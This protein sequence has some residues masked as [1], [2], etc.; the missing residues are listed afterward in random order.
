LTGS[1]DAIL[2]MAAWFLA[3]NAPGL[4]IERRGE[5]VG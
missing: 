3:R 1:I 2:A 5:E 4:A